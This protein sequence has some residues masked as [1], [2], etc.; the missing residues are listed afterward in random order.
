MICTSKWRRP[1]ARLPHDGE[2]L[3]E[4]RVERFAAG[5][6]FAEVA[7]ACGE[8]FVV[9]RG[10]AALEVCN[11]ALNP[12]VALELLLVRIAEDVE[13]FAQHVM[14]GLRVHSSSHPHPPLCVDLSQEES[15]IKAAN[16]GGK[17][18]PLIRIHE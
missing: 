9:E 4:E 17:V 7:R 10:E 14:N 12:L 3:G 11:V 1:I 15:G 18:A 16:A 6:P 5:Y 8:G 2:R 13:Q